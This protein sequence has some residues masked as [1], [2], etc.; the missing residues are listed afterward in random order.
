MLINGKNFTM[1]VD[2]GRWRTIIN[3]GSVEKMVFQRPL[4]VGGIPEE[5]K[6]G[7]FK[8]WHVRNKDSF[9][10]RNC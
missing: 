8:K 5:V 6:D 9:I 10:G 1:R 3:E 7:A 2:N 4:Y